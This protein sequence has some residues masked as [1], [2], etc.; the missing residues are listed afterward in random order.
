MLSRLHAIRRAARR[1]HGFTLI[2]TLVSVSVGM[3]VLF[4]LLQLLEFTLPASQHVTDR[5]DAQQRGRNALE[6][7]QQQLHSAVCVNTNDPVTGVPALRKPVISADAQQVTF[8][9]DVMTPTTT[10]TT[11][12]GSFQPVRRQLAWSSTAGTITEST[13]VGTGTPPNITF[14][15]T[16]TRTRT[17]LTDAWAV[18]G[19]T[20][21]FS[22]QGYSAATSALV[23]TTVA[24][25][26]AAV[27]I[28]FRVSPAGATAGS[29]Q[30]ASF[31]DSVAL[32]VSP[33]FS[34]AT[35]A[36]NGPLCS[37]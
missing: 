17:V 5:V 11:T 6:Q 7:I 24:D 20:G 37:V 34:T 19:A 25:Q 26:V 12:A 36:A 21:I 9:S 8:Y 27:G 22:P 33:D 28:S 13:W 32:T 2:E 30:G 14:P 18:G 16:P 10:A 35:A 23:P 31:D 3:V 1:E 29:A 15:A 4:G